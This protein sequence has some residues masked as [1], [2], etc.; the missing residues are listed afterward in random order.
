MLI[1]MDK[2]CNIENG[3]NNNLKLETYIHETA[4]TS[5]A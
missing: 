1:L 2:V 3:N 4:T 5:L